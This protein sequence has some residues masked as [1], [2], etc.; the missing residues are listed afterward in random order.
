MVTSFRNIILIAF[1]KAREWGRRTRPGRAML[2]TVKL[3]RVPS[4]TI[5]IIAG[6]N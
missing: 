5:Q 3:V 1:S 2:T 6:L 4:V